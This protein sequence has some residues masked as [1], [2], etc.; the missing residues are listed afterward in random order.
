MELD[1]LVA[2]RVYGDLVFSG[3]PLPTAGGEVFA[4]AFTI[5]PGG[6]ANRAVA[7]ARL[8]ASTSLLAEFGDDPIGLVVAEMLQAE[9]GLDLSASI[10][11]GGYQSPVSVAITDGPDR[12]FVTFELPESMPVWTGSAPRAVHVGLG[13]NGGVPEWVRPLRQAGS[14][15]FGGVG[16]DPTGAWSPALLD[17]LVEVDAVVF[18]EIEATSYTRTATARE[19]LEALAESV[20][21]AVVT[22]GPEGA[23]AASGRD[24]VHVPALRVDAVDPTG[25][26]DAFTGAFMSATAWGWPLVERTRLAVAASAFSVR[27]PGGARSNPTPDRLADLLDTLAPQ[28]EW[29]AVRA[30]TRDASHPALPD[31]T[32]GNLAS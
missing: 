30:W 22:L 5:S 3:A 6:A 28:P 19:A 29:D 18:N 21:I 10:F 9:P 13:A 1:V 12:S 23:L 4:E 20:R 8:G 2:G 11:R 31:T 26:G 14:V 25:A 17:A 24:R 16:W 7:S 27:T 15:V 32:E